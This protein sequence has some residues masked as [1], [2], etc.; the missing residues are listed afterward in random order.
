MEPASVLWSHRVLDPRADPQGHPGTQLHSKHRQQPWTHP[1]HRAHRPCHRQDTARGPRRLRQD[2]SHEAR[3]QSTAHVPGAEPKAASAAVA[4]QPP[5][6]PEAPRDGP[7]RAHSL[8]LSQPEQLQLRIH[9]LQARQKFS[10][11]SS[12]VSEHSYFQ[13]NMTH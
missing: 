10:E 9:S 1:T 13:V 4:T 5:W 2:D 11:V 8:A 6:R 3:P 12:R 7:R